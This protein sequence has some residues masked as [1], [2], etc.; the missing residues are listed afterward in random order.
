MGKYLNN[1][2][3]KKKRWNVIQNVMSNKRVNWLRK[4]NCPNFFLIFSQASQITF[5]L[6]A[7]AFFSDR[8]G[9]YVYHKDWNYF[10]L[11]VHSSVQV[12]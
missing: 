7:Y 1:D 8:K 10:T 5:A 9:F 6:K 11:R 12:W 4:E 2:S 3:T